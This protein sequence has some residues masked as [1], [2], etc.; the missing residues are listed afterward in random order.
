MASSIHAV[1]LHLYGGDS[2]GIVLQ[3]MGKWGAEVRTSVITN[4][5]KSVEKG[6][7]PGRNTHLMGKTGP[8]HDDENPSFIED[9]DV[10]ILR[11]PRTG[12]TCDRVNNP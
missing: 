5:R 12:S 1:W 4:C 7:S 6:D 8:P 3:S 10:S 2:V 11:N 9:W